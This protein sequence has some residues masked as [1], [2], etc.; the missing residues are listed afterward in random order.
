M[1]KKKIRFF[2][3]NTWKRPFK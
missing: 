1:Q 3:Q 2:G